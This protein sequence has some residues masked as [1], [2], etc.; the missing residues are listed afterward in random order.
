MKHFTNYSLK[1]HNTL[2]IDVKCDD[3]YIVE[4]I[5]DVKELAQLEAMRSGNYMLLGDGA[6]VLFTQDYHG[7]I[8]LIA[9]T[10]I[11]VI[12]ESDTDVV[13]EADAGTSWHELVKYTV[14]HGW[15]G[16]ENMA[17]IP[18]KVGASPVG[19]IAAYGQNF[20]DVCESVQILRC[21]TGEITYMDAQSCAFTYR[22]SIFKHELKGKAIILSV[23]LRLH[24]NP[25]VNSEYWSKKHGSVGDMLA[26]KGPGPYTIRD[27]FDAICALRMSKF[28]D[29]EALGTAGSFFTNP[30]VTQEQLAHILKL[31]PNVQYYPVEDLRYIDN[32]QLTH[33]KHVK[34][35]AGEI[36]DAGMGYKGLWIGNV[37]LFEKHALVLVT[38]GKAT[39]AEVDAFAKKIEKDF[40]EYCGV[41]LKREVITI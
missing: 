10:D 19:N 37:G 5:E 8:V 33:E 30:I 12:S 27:V 21:A 6:N 31:V 36:L 39:G 9:L 4:T 34:I 40:F 41:E 3:L 32:T 35:A 26:Q 16:I 38:N 25:M 23:R 15:G 28:P 20:S 13:I 18:G 14:D 2:K 1:E 29:M 17:L 22:D 24:K 11:K 7:T